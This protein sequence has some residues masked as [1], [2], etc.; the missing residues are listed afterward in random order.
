MPDDFTAMLPAAV[1]SIVT[2]PMLVGIILLIVLNIINNI[3]LRPKYEKM[4]PDE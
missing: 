4:N 1:Q 2:Q 3:L